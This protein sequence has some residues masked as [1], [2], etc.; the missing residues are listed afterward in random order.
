ME[1]QD[2]LARVEQGLVSHKAHLAEMERR[3]HEV[4]DEGKIYHAVEHEL[5]NALRIYQC[6]TEELLRKVHQARL[7]IPR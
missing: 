1:A 4:T 5:V 7:E 3:I 2:L 6:N